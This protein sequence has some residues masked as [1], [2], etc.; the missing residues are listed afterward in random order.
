MSSR[1]RP[2]RRGS[3]RAN[4]SAQRTQ[5]AFLDAARRV[6]CRRNYDQAGLRDIAAI[7]GADKRLV[8]RYFG[9]KE[10]LFAAALQSSVIKFKPQPADYP[11]FGERYVQRIFGASELTDAD[12]FEFISLC[13]HSASS[14]TGRRLVRA[15][16]AQQIRGM[17]A[18]LAGPD[19]AVRACMVLA[20][21]F[22]G[23]LMREVMR[24]D[25][26]VGLSV[27]KA[28]IY[29][30]PLV[31]SLVDGRPLRWTKAAPAIRRRRA[32][33]PRSALSRQPRG[34]IG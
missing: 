31:Q 16:V 7:A 4:G 10:R 15:N 5:A 28:S 9:S 14:P 12:R 11:R 30:A 24:I 32:L 3:A 8:T 25:E 1:A 22:G 13:I 18:N 33:S 19:A 20:V 29:V 26:L 27:E 17:A 21:C 2:P 34:Q 23:A 6:F